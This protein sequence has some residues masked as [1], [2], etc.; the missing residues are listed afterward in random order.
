MAHTTKENVNVL[1]GPHAV[2]SSTSVTLDDL[3]NIVDNINAEVNLRAGAAGF[4]TDE[5]D[6]TNIGKY[7]KSVVQ[8]GAAASALKGLFP[9][10]T[11]PGTNPAFA[12]WEDRY[13]K[14]LAYFDK[15]AFEEDVAVSTDD[16]PLPSTYFTRNRN[17]DEELGDLVEGLD[18]T[19]AGSVF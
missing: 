15:L 9:E 19:R 3:E 1:L 11:G 8:W 16:P 2:S 13:Q 4:S 18:I 10:A 5:S 6:S 7:L 14:A 17:Q 12:F